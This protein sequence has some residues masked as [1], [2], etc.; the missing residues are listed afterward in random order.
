MPAKT[1][2]K[3]FNLEDN[4][5]KTD[6][7]QKQPLN[8]YVRYSGLGFQMIAIFL[9]AAYAG[10]K[11]DELWALSFPAMTLSLLLLAVVVSMIVLVKT[12]SSNS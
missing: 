9:A 6:K 4:K 3:K 12:I 11:L 7:K 5:P 2:Q 10:R 1:P 8:A